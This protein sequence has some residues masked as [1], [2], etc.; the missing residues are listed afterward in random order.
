LNINNLNNGDIIKDYKSLC[1]MLGLEKAKTGEA[2]TKHLA[3]L[4]EYVDYTIDGRKFIINKVIKTNY[5]EKRNKRNTPKHITSM[6]LLLLNMLREAQDNVQYY[7]KTALATALHLI[8]DRYGELFSNRNRKIIAESIGSDEVYITDFFNSSTPA[9]KSALNT[10]LSQLEKDGAIFCNTVTMITYKN[11]N[12]VEETIPA[13]STELKEMLKIQKECMKKFGRTMQDI[14]NKN[15]SDEYYFLLKTTLRE[16][17]GITYH[18]K[19]YEIQGLDESLEDEY[20]FLLQEEGIDPSVIDN[21]KHYLGQRI[22][23][24]W[25]QSS[26]KRFSTRKRNALKQTSFGDV[27]DIYKPRVSDSYEKEMEQL[28]NIFVR[29]KKLSVNTI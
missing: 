22:Y 9:Y 15:L 1:M 28:Y 16:K 10:I 17:L 27:K 20:N 4:L 11:E 29:S 14:Y 3:D 2:K 25:H 23:K 21:M 5:I 6:K 19:A 12:N 7:S 13:T 8:G 26:M 18:Y 24:E